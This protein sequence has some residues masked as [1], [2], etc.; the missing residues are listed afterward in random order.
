MKYWANKFFFS[1]PQQFLQDVLSIINSDV[2]E[3]D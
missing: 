1:G 2:G 3:L